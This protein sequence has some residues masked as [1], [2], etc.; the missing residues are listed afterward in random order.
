MHLLIWATHWSHCDGNSLHYQCNKQQSFSVCN[1]LNAP[2]TIAILGSNIFHFNDYYLLGCNSVC[3]GRRSP[4]FQ[5][6]VP[7]SSGLKSKPWKQDT[8]VESPVMS[9]TELLVP[10]ITKQS[11][12]PLTSNFIC[13]V[14]PGL[15]CTLLCY[16]NLQ[17]HET[18]DRSCLVNLNH[19]PSDHQM[20][21]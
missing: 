21:L 1:F 19:H 10:S 2:C 20:R 7:P 11:T 12:H 16:T 14:T 15:R 8:S 9:I 17:S 18:S 3:F 4:V 5:R 6:K 13:I